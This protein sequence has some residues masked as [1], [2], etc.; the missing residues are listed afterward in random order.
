MYS[1]LLREIFSTCVY[2]IR[3]EAFLN[4]QQAI[5]YNINNHIPAED[6]KFNPKEEDYNIYIGNDGSLIIAPISQQP[7][8]AG[9]AS[10]S[11]TEASASGAS[12]A[13]VPAASAS[14]S[15]QPT[16]NS[17]R[18]NN[19]DY[20]MMLNVCGPITRSGGMCTSGSVEHRDMLLSAASDE[21][22]LGVCFIVDTPGGSS[23]SMNDYRQGLDAFKE[24]GKRSITFVD[25]QCLSLGMA[26]GCQTDYIV[27]MNGA[28]EVGC[29]G[30]MAAGF[31]PV[32]DHVNA[33]GLRFVHIVASQTPEKN[34]ILHDASEGN[35]EKLQQSIDE[36]AQ[37]FLDLIEE[38]RPQIL[39]EQRKGKVY[40]ADSVIGTL[41]DGIGTVD[42]CINYILTG[43]LELKV[44]PSSAASASGA[45]SAASAADGSAV[46]TQPG[47]AAAASPSATEAS[48]SGASPATVPAASAE[49]PQQQNNPNTEN[50]MIKM[51]HILAA[52]NL[53]ELPVQDGGIFLN[54]E[55]A[56]QLD[57]VLA[58][59]EQAATEQPE[60]P[61]TE[62]PGEAS[63][64]SPAGSAEGGSP[65]VTEQPG[66]AAAAA[67]ATEEEEEH[68]A[69]EQPA[70]PAA[71][72]PGEAAAAA[73]EDSAEG[74]S[75]AVTEQPGEAATAAPAAAS[76]AGSAEGGSPAAPTSEQ[77][78][79]AAGTQQPAAE[80][81]SQ[82][83]IV[84]QYE[85]RI[86]DM[87]EQHN[88][89]MQDLRDQLAELANSTT[90]APAPKNKGVAAGSVAEPPKDYRKMTIAEKK[91]AW[92]NIG[93][94]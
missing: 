34:K 77:P 13:T 24:A 67:P 55:L 73:P 59:Q 15:Q 33:S 64:A 16:A 32:H 21:H 37:K 10:L 68:P 81:S 29:V 61:A 46:G 51:T 78:E 53:K 86:R 70:A 50:N 19:L 84:E 36:S 30:A 89:E 60:A 2:W 80:A 88:R 26:L 31:I 17:Q 66:E 18:P 40:R 45:S 75:P 27:C 4:Y 93:K 7:G 47:E 83:A 28:D 65:A 74:G 85:A 41:V 12:P 82:N 57:G 43:N 42:D 54:E 6:I 44:V 63:A 56:N 48:A 8:E 76:P 87:Q 90:P 69:T 91:A 35:Y 11:A 72:Q 1:K 14:G 79:A 23:F 38:M 92:D 9:A 58:A 5:L 39:P 49:G 25:G 20:V 71:E 62:Q 22:C 52:L 3:E 94:K